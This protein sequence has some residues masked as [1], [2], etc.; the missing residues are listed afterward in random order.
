MVSIWRFINSGVRSGAFNMEC[1]EKLALELLAG[2]GVPTLR[3]YQWEP[4]SISLGYNQNAADI[5]SRKCDQDGIDIVRRPTGGRAILHAQELTYSIVMRAGRS[6]VLQVYNDISRALVRGLEMFGVDV[7]LQRLQPNFAEAYRH[8]SSIPCFTSSARYEIEYEGRKL[9]GSAQRRYSDGEQDVILQHGS[10]LCG[11][12]HQ[13]LADY[14]ALDD[15][16]TKKR[17]SDELRTKTADLASLSGTELDLDSLALCIRRGFEEEWDI[18]LTEF[19][20]SEIN[21]DMRN[22]E[23]IHTR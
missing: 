14:L 18:T 12:G 15:A 13:R 7:T 2:N 8:A 5:D 21:H 17:I 1:D 23:I 6:G 11:P 20:E 16:A 10:I 9:V 22:D 4:W 3:L 19:T